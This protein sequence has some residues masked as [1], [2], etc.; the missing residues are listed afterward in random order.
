M[1]SNALLDYAEKK[2]LEKKN[3]HLEELFMEIADDGWVMTG[4]INVEEDE[5]EE[6][7]KSVLDGSWTSSIAVDSLNECVDQSC[8]CTRSRNPAARSCFLK[9]ARQRIAE[10][11]AGKDQVAYASLGSGLLRFDFEFLESALADGVPISTVHLVD[12]QYE[13][14]AEKAKLH[15]RALA[16]FVAWFA[17]RGVDV[18]A[19]STFEKFSFHARNS[20]LLPVAVFQVDCAELV[21]IFESVVKPLLEEVLHYGG[22]FCALTARGTTSGDGKMGAFDAWGEVLGEDDALPPAS[23]H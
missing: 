12:S 20:Q 6:I 9:V 17:R 19:H 21:W 15:R 23:V 13:K 2:F 7:R 14:S 22:V 10:V 1:P 4:D 11:S 3:E 5:Q 8:G 18:Y 16:Q